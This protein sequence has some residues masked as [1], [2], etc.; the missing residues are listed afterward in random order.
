[1][2]FNTKFTKILAVLM[3][4][5]ISISMMGCGNK[6]PEVPTEAEGR[7]VIH[8]AASYVTAEVQDAYKELIKVYNE[9]QGVVDGVYVQFRESPGPIAGL[10]SVLRNN[11]QYDVIQL[12]DD[13][14][15]A[16][17]IQGKNFFVNL[18]TYLTDEMK[19]AM[20]WDDIPSSMIDRFRLDTTPSSNGKFMAGAGASLLALPNGSNPQILFYN[21]TILKNAGINIVSVPESELAAY[22]TT[23][24]AKLVPHGYAEY[25]EAPFEGAVSS[26]NEAGAKVYKVFNDCIGMNW[27]EQRCLARAFQKQYGCEYGFMSE[28]WFNMGFSVGGDCIG[29]DV[30]S[31]NYKLTLG[32]KQPGYLALEDIT[33]NGNAYKKGEVLHYEDKTF[34]NNNAGE[35]ATLNGKVYPMPSTYDAILEF[36]RLGVPSNKLVDNGAYGY[37]VAPSSTENRTVRFLSGTDCPFLIEDFNQTKSFKN[38]LG[39]ALG[40]AVPAQYREYVGGSVYTSGSNEYLK[41]VG[42]TYDGQVYTGELHMENGTPIV[43]EATTESQVAG[44]FLPTNTKNKNYD[45]AFK[46]AA[47][48]AG[49]EGQTIL[50]KGNRDLPNQASI[51]MG[52]EYADSADRLVSNVWAAAYVLQKADIGD[53][54][55]FTSVTWITEWSKPFNG[56]VREGKMTLSDF[57]KQYKESA[58]T[59]LQGMRLYIKG[60]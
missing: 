1:M 17:A 11:Y 34:L 36:T 13:E 28:W 41:V 16:L 21:K 25:K 12:N 2:K 22:N 54:T 42:E 18:D 48:V 49:P 59:G 58:D 55:Y 33:V 51:A 56:D 50:A 32:D 57:I 53:Y 39:D 9:T 26:Q 15:K 52:D 14:Y 3:V 19:T 44:L 4:T 8:F 38:S 5:I 20:A 6:N 45:E 29:W 10:E 27:E 30:A 31:G 46:F 47:W 23:N 35:L 43:G 7:K 60:R 24:N 40:M 37:G